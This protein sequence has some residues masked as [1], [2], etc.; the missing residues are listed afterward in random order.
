MIGEE[1][2]LK[3]SVRFDLNYRMARRGVVGVRLQYLNLKFLGDENMNVAYQ[4]LE[5]FRKGHNLSWYIN[6]Q[7]NLSEFLQL[8]LKYEG[9][10]SQH[11]KIIHLGM[12]QVKAHF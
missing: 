7:T 3:N 4:M 5:G 11:S 12:L 2:N 10:V 1:K 6:M 8:D 9:R